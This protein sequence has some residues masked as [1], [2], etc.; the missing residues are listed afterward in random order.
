MKRN[1]APPVACVLCVALGAFLLQ[2]HI[3]VFSGT[4]NSDAKFS[5]NL[6][7]VSF[8]A[9]VSFSE[10][11]MERGGAGALWLMFLCSSNGLVVA[12]SSF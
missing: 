1:D 3:S 2:A 5:C 9:G 11:L 4:S 10:L 12:F 7:F 8:F 6:K